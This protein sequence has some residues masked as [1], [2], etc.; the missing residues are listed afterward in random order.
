MVTQTVFGLIHDFEEHS[1]PIV[2]EI[3]YR[4][5]SYTYKPL[6]LTSNR[7]RC[8]GSVVVLSL[9]SCFS[10]LLKYA[11]PGIPQLALKWFTIY[12]HFACKTNFVDS[13]TRRPT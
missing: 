1:R 7:P 3:T 4:P 8:G 2:L 5:S 11:Y 6:K 9:F 13:K 10:S 12:T